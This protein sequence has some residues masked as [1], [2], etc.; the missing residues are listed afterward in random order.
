MALTQAQAQALS[1]DLNFKQ[2]VK[3]AAMTVAWQILVS[4]ASSAPSKTYA[5]ALLQSPDAYAAILAQWLVVRTNV[6][7]STASVDLSSGTPIVQ[8]S[9]T[10]ADIQSQLSTDWV[11]IAGG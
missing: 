2:R 10:D 11:N 4:G 7:Q 9:A 8:T 3:N 1:T 5:R 6:Q